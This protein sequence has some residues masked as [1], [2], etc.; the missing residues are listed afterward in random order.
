MI[1][2]RIG[3][4]VESWIRIEIGVEMLTISQ[5]GLEIV[6]MKSRELRGFISC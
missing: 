2:I 6:C 5:S 1:R 4:K 3:V